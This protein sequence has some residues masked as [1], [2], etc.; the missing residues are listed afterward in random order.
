MAFAP[1]RV[2][3]EL[4]DTVGAAEEP[5]FDVGKDAVPPDALDIGFAEVRFMKW[6]G[7]MAACRSSLNCSLA[8]STTSA[9][10]AISVAPFL[11]SQRRSKPSIG[12]SS[13]WNST[14]WNRRRRAR[15]TSAIDRSAVFIVPMMYRL[16]GSENG[17]SESPEY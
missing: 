7:P 11:L 15:S 3:G 12:H 16:S 14:K 4:G 13:G 10:H 17:V 8:R 5:F 1:Q 2:Q 6:L 9:T